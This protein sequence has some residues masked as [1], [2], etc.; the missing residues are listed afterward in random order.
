MKFKHRSLDYKHQVGR[1]VLSTACDKDVATFAFGQEAQWRNGKDNRPHLYVEGNPGGFRD[2]SGNRISQS[3]LGAIAG[4]IMAPEDQKLE[5]A[6]LGYNFGRSIDNRRNKLTVQKALF[7][8]ERFIKNNLLSGDKISR[9]YNRAFNN[10]KYKNTKENT[11]ANLLQYYGNSNFCRDRYG[12]SNCGL[13]RILGFGYAINSKKNYG[14]YGNLFN[15]LPLFNIP[16]DQYKLQKDIII[17]GSSESDQCVK[18]DT[19]EV[20]NESATK[21]PEKSKEKG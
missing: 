11:I 13:I 14:R 5:G 7:K 19:D 10:E 6:L 18:K 2:E 21:C 15:Q 3:L 8:T 4:Y 9:W 12:S 20:N 17:I 16:K 1:I